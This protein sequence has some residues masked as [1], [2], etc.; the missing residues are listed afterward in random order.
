M[1]HNDTKTT[2]G[3]R[4]VFVTL[5]IAAVG[6]SSSSTLADGQLGAEFF[7]TYP[8]NK[9]EMCEIIASHPSYREKNWETNNCDKQNLFKPIRS[10]QSPAYD[11]ADMEQVISLS[12]KKD[13]DWPLVDVVVK[14]K[15]TSGY[16]SI[17]T[18]SIDGGEYNLWDYM[19]EEKHGFSAVHISHVGGVILIRLEHQ[20]ITQLSITPEYCE[21][22]DVGFGV[23]QVFSWYPP[24]QE[25]SYSKSFYKTPGCN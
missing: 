19:A 3:I 8:L 6:L 20:S 11:E 18:L 16:L 17:D 13:D 2:F 22:G 10:I 15:S 12:S 24:F 23:S 4:R 9:R 7:E 1:R 5:M 25:E 21:D 14:T